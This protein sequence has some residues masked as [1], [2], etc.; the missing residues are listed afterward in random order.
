MQHLQGFESNGERKATIVQAMERWRSDNP[1]VTVNGMCK[2]FRKEMQ[3]SVSPSTLEKYMREVDSELYKSGFDRETVFI[4][5]VRGIQEAIAEAYEEGKYETVIRG[6]QRLSSLLD[7]DGY[8]ADSDK[9]AVSKFT[10]KMLEVFKEYSSE[11]SEE[12]S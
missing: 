2:K 3:I 4:N 10:D 12:E 9:T 11:L 6:N 1:F 5:Q 8:T 7:L